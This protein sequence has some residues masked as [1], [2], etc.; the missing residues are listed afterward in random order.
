MLLLLPLLL[1]PL[2]LPLLL[3]PLLLK[4]LQHCRVPACA[5]SKSVS[6]LW[7]VCSEHG[8]AVNKTMVPRACN[9]H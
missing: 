1:L 5:N 4:K 7:C 8:R 2:L 6:C 9:E 3:L